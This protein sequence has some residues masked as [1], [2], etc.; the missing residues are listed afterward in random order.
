MNNENSSRQY[1]VDLIAALRVLNLAYHH[2]HTLASGPNFAG[3]HALLQ[4][5]YFGEDEDGA[6]SPI[7]E[8]D[9]VMEKLQGLLPRAPLY[10]DEIA[11]AVAD[12][13]QQNKAP[14]TV[15]GRFQQLLR[16]EKGLQGVLVDAI[17]HFESE[18]PDP[19]VANMLQTI[20]D[21]RQTNIYLLQ[22]RL[23]K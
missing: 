20:V 6:D 22:Q 2:A 14:D 15:D 13:F 1:L 5:L 18:V 19:G 21:D 12:A 4:R 11:F 9:T 7:L 3:D 16:F 10:A 17:A 8:I 23:G